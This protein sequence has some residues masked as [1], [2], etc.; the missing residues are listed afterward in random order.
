MQ[1]TRAKS[2]TWKNILAYIASNIYFQIYIIG[3]SQLQLQ[4]NFSWGDTIIT[5]HNFAPGPPPPPHKLSGKVC[6]FTIKL[7]YTLFLFPK[8]NKSL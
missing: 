1:N 7:N 2:K 4:L 8:L 6:S 3:T 5:A